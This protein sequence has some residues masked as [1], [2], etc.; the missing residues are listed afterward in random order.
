MG[1][2]SWVWLQSLDH[3]TCVVQFEPTFMRRF[4]KLKYQN[5]KH[6]SYRIK[7]WQDKVELKNKKIRVK[8][9]KRNGKNKSSVGHGN[10]NTTRLLF[11]FSIAISKFR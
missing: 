8:N 2:K 1:L 10:V 6:V 5:Y 9:R 4:K 7:Q 3:G 11:C